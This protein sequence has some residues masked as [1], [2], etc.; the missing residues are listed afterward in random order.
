MFAQTNTVSDEVVNKIR[1]LLALGH[2]NNQNESE[3]AMTKAKKLALEH[4]IDLSLI[5]AFAGQKEEPI[6]RGE[7]VGVGQ[8]E[9]TCQKYINW[10]LRDHFNVRIVNSGSRFW[11]R[12]IV[13]I[14]KRRDIDIA[15][16][17]HGFLNSEM[18]R[19][20]HRFYKQN[21][22]PL[23]QKQSYL[24]GIYK[25]LSEKLEQ[26]VR[27]TEQNKFDEIKALRGV[28]YG[29]TAQNS[30]ALTVKSNREKLEEKLGEFYPHLRK[31][32]RSTININ[33][34]GAMNAGKAAGRQI[35]LNRPIG[36]GNNNRLTN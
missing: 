20:W 3:L 32:S 22:G 7:G 18:P 8:R 9:S 36:N 35:N 5:D 12:S 21:G 17:V 4:E 33:S 1:K 23:S 11:G 6:L 27:E 34:M 14:G 26:S 24:Y 16:Y 19:L 31:S 2:S 28:E 25:G 15:T 10:L 13:F 30:W 29:T